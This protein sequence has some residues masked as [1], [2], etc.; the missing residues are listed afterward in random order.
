MLGC[1]LLAL[2]DHRGD[3][4]RCRKNNIQ[5]VTSSGIAVVLRRRYIFRELYF[6]GT[7][8]KGSEF[9]I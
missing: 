1:L 8:E 7:S 2:E 6:R 9:P 4:L 3:G 5:S